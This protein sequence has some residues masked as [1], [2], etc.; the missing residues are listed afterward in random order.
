MK[1]SSLLFSI[2]ALF[3]STISSGDPIQPKASENQS[4]FIENCGQIKTQGNTTNNKVR[5]LWPA[6]EGLNIQ[7][8]NTGISFDTY[9]TTGSETKFHRMD[10]DIL[11]INSHCTLAGVEKRS[12]ALNFYDKKSKCT[13]SGVEQF[14]GVTY[15]NVYDQIDFAV[16]LTENGKLKYDFI[17]ENPEQTDEIKLKY[18]GFDSFEIC[19]GN[20]VFDLSGRQIT[21]TIP[22]SW[23]SESGREI[24]VEYR[25]IEKGTN[26]V[27][28]GFE[29]QNTILNHSEGHLIIDPLAILEWGTYYGDSLYDVGNAIATDSLGNV[30]VTGTTS[31][32]HN[33]A[34]DGLYQTVYSG[35]T[36]DAYI[37]KMNQHGLRHWATYYGGSGNDKGLGI[38]VDSYGTIY[39]VRSTTSTDSIG[40]DGAQQTANGGGTD[41]FI[42]HFDRFGNFVWDSFIGSTGEEEAIACKADGYG[43]VVVVGNTNT[44]GFLQNDTVPTLFDYQGGTDVFIAKYNANGVLTYTSYYGG[45]SD[46]FATSVTLDSLSNM[47]VAGY[48]NSAENIAWGSALQ[49]DLDGETDGFAMKLDSTGGIAWATYLGGPGNDKLTGVTSV[50]GDFYFSGSTDSLTTYTDTT[51]FQQDYAG[52]GDAFIARISSNGILEWYSYVGGEGTDVANGISR[53]YD[54]QIYIVGTTTSDSTMS[55]DTTFIPSPVESQDVFISKFNQAGERI[56]GEYYGGDSYDLG[57]SIAVFGHTSV[58]ITGLTTSQFGISQNG[59]E[60]YAY[61]STNSNLDT[62]GFMARFTQ[63]QSTL[64]CEGCISGGGGYSGGGGGNGGGGNGGGYNPIGI[65]IGDSILLSL[66]GGALGQGAQWVWYVDTCGGTDNFIGEGTQIWVTPDTTT[67]YYVRAESVEDIT[68]CS[69]VVVHVD[70]PNTAI[71][72]ANDSICPGSTLELFGDGGYYYNWF[73]SDTL[74]SEEQNPVIDTVLASQAGEYTLIANTQFGCSDTTTVDVF[75]YPGPQF[76]VSSTDPSCYESSDGSIAITSNDTLSLTYEWPLFG[77]SENSLDSLIAGTYSAIVTNSIG[78]SASANATLID[79]EEVVDSL[80]ITPA[81]CDNPNGAGQILLYGG[82]SPY[83][84]EWN[85]VDENGFIVEDLYAGSYTV[86]FADANGCGDST[87]F[88]IPNLGEFTAVIDPDSILLGYFDSE[89]LAVY[90]IP[91]LENPSYSWT[92]TEGLSCA[93][94]SNPLANPSATIWYQVLVTSQH[95]CTSTDSLFVE[96]ELPAPNSFIPNMFSPNGDGLND[97][98]CVLGV[99]MVSFKLSIY[100]RFGK[101]IFT[102]SN[103]E[104]CWD[105]NI[106]GTPASGSFVYTFEAILEEGKSVNETGNVTIQR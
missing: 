99:R 65:C 105:G 33:M 50:N 61:M 82:T 85:P 81:Y 46:D 74:I 47:V 80:V 96:R 104:N 90:T 55:S 69:K 100:D 58:Y 106:D 9:Q 88:S 12:T 93:D 34:S 48:T 94:C 72:S 41:G 95:G 18:S 59:P 73:A 27:V 4:G 83:T 17:L 56:W 78:C 52:N 103:T 25:I 45:D 35:G 98:L 87:Q 97:K 62:L 28:I 91:E 92:P 29:T 24:K 102:S 71:A 63:Y 70:Y 38:D 31:S 53:D 54:G 77:S 39:V 26:Y 32:L 66:N 3:L 86:V 60:E 13:I 6:A 22:A 44:G 75:L 23:M 79:P 19:D 89:E 21:E 11:G 76:S 20:L 84:V 30:F 5:Y 51:S 40:S 68:N 14:N 16:S 64:P 15:A 10:V 36:S 42:A 7:L 8:R 101:I 49:Y 2:F 1:Y 57:R 43:N 37:V 67:S